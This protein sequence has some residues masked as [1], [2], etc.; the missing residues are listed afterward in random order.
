M[1]RDPTC[2]L[3]R[4]P[5]WAHPGRFEGSGALR[6]GS[7]RILPELLNPSPAVG[8]CQ[9]AAKACEVLWTQSPG[10]RRALQRRQMLGKYLPQRLE[11]LNILGCAALNETYAFSSPIV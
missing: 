9:M 6:I 10:E 3:V 4:G 11:A 7:I 5:A 8:Y 1:H 2:R